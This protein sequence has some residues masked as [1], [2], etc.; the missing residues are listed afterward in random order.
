MSS[1]EVTR[2]RSH[3]DGAKAEMG[4]LTRAPL[5]SCMIQSTEQGRAPFPGVLHQARPLG[6][7][8]KYH[9]AVLSPCEQEEAPSL[10]RDQNNRPLI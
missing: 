3:S 4:F 8:A 7:P 9:A 6:E 5:F 10:S 2:F 1:G